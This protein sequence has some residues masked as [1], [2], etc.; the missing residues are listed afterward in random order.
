VPFWINFA[1]AGIG[2]AFLI[3]MAPKG[4]FFGNVAE[5]AEVSRL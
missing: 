2:Y 4:N 1:D 5:V 3:A